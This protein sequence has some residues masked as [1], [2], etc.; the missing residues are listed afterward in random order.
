M[1][2][3][4]LLVGARSWGAFDA[5]LGASA[6]RLSSVFY[7]ESSSVFVE[8]LY[9]AKVITRLSWSSELVI[10]CTMESTLNGEFG[11]GI[12][13]GLIWMH[14]CISKPAHCRGTES[15]LH[16]KWYLV[17]S[18]FLPGSSVFLIPRGLWCWKG[19]VYGAIL[20]SGSSLG[21]AGELSQATSRPHCGLVWLQALSFSNMFPV[22]MRSSE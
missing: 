20:I 15:A 5:A 3:W 18:L 19:G 16:S 6:C 21:L 14:F 17:V 2:S 4:R 9:M 11:R 12:A 7:P 22:L 10:S 1:N 8:P 13:Q